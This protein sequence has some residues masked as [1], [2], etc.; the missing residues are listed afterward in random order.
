MSD[1]ISQPEA[2]KRLGI[3]PLTIHRWRKRPELAFPV[4][5]KIGDRVFFRR[6]EVDAW[7]EARAQSAVKEIA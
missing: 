7:I 5:I 6:A 1:L 2:C 4:S 3:R